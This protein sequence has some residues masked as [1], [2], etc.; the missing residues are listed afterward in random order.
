[1]EPLREAEPNGSFAS[2]NLHPAIFKCISREGFTSPTAIQTQAIPHIING[3]DMLGLAQTGTGKTAAFVLPIVHALITQ[4]RPRARALVLTPTRELAE[5]VFQVCKAFSIGSPVRAMTMYGG[6]AYS[7]QLRDLAQKPDI[8][9]ACPGR[10]LDHLDQGTVDLRGIE[11]LVLDEADQMFDMGF[12]PNIRRII[13]RLPRD[14]QT[15]L[16]S[17]TMPEELRS[18]ALEILRDPVNVDVNTGRAVT[19]ISHA[20]YE[21]QSSG[22]AAMLYKL[23]ET[24]KTESVLI[25]TRTKHRAKKL[26]RDLDQDGYRATSLQ[27]NLSQSQRTRAMDGFRKGRYTIM[28]ATDIA[29]R[30]IDISTVSH[31]INF[32]VPDTVEAYVHRIGRTGRAAR[33]GDA[34]T[35]VTAEDVQMVRAIEKRLGMRIERREVPGLTVA[36][37]VKEKH[38]QRRPARRQG[39]ESRKG[40]EQRPRR[41]KFGDRRRFT[42]PRAKGSGQQPQPRNG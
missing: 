19:T 1:M 22:K 26:A 34:L 8:I 18:L 11:I 41:K 9:V 7:R 38:E 29:A 23:L 36:L 33:T 27:G 4:R 32:D 10:L 37:V 2:F 42:P 13:A 28:V 31:V 3:K 16:F 15:L 39:I 5:Q 24:M 12:L 40:N 35:L 6:V 21:V 25:F 30:G 14:R 17:A 20:I